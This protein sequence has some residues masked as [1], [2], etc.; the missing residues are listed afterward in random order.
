VSNL[1]E[2]VEQAILM[3]G[4]LKR[5]QRVLV[6]VSGGLDSMVLVHA[7]HELSLKHSWKLT[8]AHLNHRLRG[9]SSDAD[10]RLVVRTARQLHLLVVVERA[11]VRRISRTHRLSIEMAARNVRHEFLAR[12]AARLKIP[13]VALG[14]H[15]DDQL[16]LFFLRLFRGSGGEGLAGMKWRNASPDHP[17]I[18]LIRP[19]LGEG[20]AGLLGYARAAKVPF[21]E[22][23]SNACLDIRRNRIRHELLPLLRRRYQPALDRTVLRLMDIAGTEAELVSEV[24]ADWLSRKKRVRFAELPLAVQRRCIQLELRRSHVPADYELVERLRLFPGRKVAV[25]PGWDVVLTAEGEVLLVEV[26]AVRS[27]AFRRLSAKSRPEAELELKGERGSI[28]FGGLRIDWRIDSR[29]GSLPPK[30]VAGREFFDADKVGSRVIL[31]H[32]RP[33]DRFQP[34]GMPSPVKV[35]DLFTNR[36]IPRE[37]RHGL[38]V[39]VAAGGELVWVQNLRISERF[40]LSTAT[41]RRL[42]WRWKQLCIQ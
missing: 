35:Q 34:I 4:L 18:E 21:R 2:R 10:E 12:T 32:W 41:N 36:K 24:A 7:L 14:H 22:D 1:L 15:A 19:L 16:E 23:A 3:R 5:G 39:V 42:Q 38:V 6:A 37:Q 8:I 31:R 40:K 33:G 29:K 13:S 20:K 27:S 11:E 26:K 25:S 28:E 30:P 9:R 17:E